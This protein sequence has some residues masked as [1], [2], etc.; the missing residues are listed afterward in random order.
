[1]N[2]KSRL[3]INGGVLTPREF[4]YICEKAENLGMDTISFGSRQDIILSKNIDDIEWVDEGNLPIKLCNENKIQNVVSS[5]VSSGIFSKY[6]MA[7]QCTIF[8]YH[9]AV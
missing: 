4:K 3:L 8:V 6:V 7:H 2:K 9:R 1:M 5:Y